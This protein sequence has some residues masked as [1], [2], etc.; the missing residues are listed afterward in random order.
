MGH[1]GGRGLGACGWVVR[2]GEGHGGLAGLCLLRGAP[3]LTSRGR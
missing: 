3:S 2:V 1:A